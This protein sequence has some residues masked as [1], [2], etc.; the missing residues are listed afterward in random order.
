MSGMPVMP[1]NYSVSL[2]MVSRGGVKELVQDIPFRAV[3]LNLAT[4]PAENLEEVEAF[5]AKAAELAGTMYAAESFSE[6][7]LKKVVLIRQTLHN[8]AGTQQA[9]MDRA[10][11][12]E[13]RIKDVIFAFEG[14]EAR[15]SMEE[16]PPSPV[17]LNRRLRTVVYG[18]MGSSSGITGTQKDNY[19]I[20]REELPPLLEELKSID[21]EIIELNEELDAMGAPW[22]PG[23]IPDWQ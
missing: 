17:A 23:R 20:L 2:S 7:L 5:H 9:M 15:A 14:Q 11:G 21:R 4:L 1:G 19:E 16:I 10:S 6:D 8:T 13:K 12:I 22:T 3:P 18:S